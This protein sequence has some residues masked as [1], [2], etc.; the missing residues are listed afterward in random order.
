MRFHFLLVGVFI[1]F[2]SLFSAHLAHAVT[3]PLAPTTSPAGT[4]TILFIGDSITQG[5]GVK[6]T[7]AYPEIV[8]HLLQMRGHAVRV[9]N[10]GISGSVTAD[11]DHRMRWYLRAS[12]QIVVLALGGND[13]LKGTSPDLVKKNLSLAIDYAQSHGMKVLLCGIDVFANFGDD[14][15]ASFKKVF[16]DLASEKKVEL[17]PFLLEGVALHKDLMQP[18]QKHPNAA[19]HVIVAKNV[20]AKLEKML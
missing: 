7:Q 20:A 4:E 9:I 14:Y 2:S 17:L 13:G 11:A 6:E 16:T 8:Q 12:P 3:G 10:G 1:F 18:D 5:Y 19:G 15:R